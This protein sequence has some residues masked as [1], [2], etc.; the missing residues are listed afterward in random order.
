MQP[1]NR[2][3]STSLITW[4][5][6]RLRANANKSTWQKKTPRTLMESDSNLIKELVQQAQPA[7]SKIEEQTL[8]QLKEE[9]KVLKLVTNIIFGT[10]T[11]GSSY[12]LVAYLLSIN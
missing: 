1:S 5:L 7:R 6:A 11:I 4:Y 10:V 8:A 12:F 3:I 9:S 2:S